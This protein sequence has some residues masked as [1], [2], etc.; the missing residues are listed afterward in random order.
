LFAYYIIKQHGHHVLYLGQNLSVAYVKDVIAAYQPDYVFSILTNAMQAE[1]LQ[2]V[3]RQYI[4]H[5]SKQK[6]LLA[7]AAIN[8]HN[9]DS[10]E[11]ILTLLEVSDLLSFLNQV[12]KTFESSLTS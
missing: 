1:E 2:K 9:V 6:I 3:L 7:G 8:Q 10:L 4:Q 12:D 11:N 5:F